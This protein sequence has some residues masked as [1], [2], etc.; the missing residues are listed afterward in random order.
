MKNYL[1]WILIAVCVVFVLYDTPEKAGGESINYE[2][3][4]VVEIQPEKIKVEEIKKKLEKKEIEGPN[5][6]AKEIEDALIPMIIGV[7]AVWFV[8]FMFRMFTR[9]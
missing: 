5:E 9:I 2:I 1:N 7:I 4:E 8:A 3:M 6:M